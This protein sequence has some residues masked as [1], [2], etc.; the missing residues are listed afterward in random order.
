[1]TLENDALGK[2]HICR[3]FDGELATIYKL[4]LDMISLIR[5]QWELVIEAMEDANLES[6]LDIVAQTGDVHRYESRIDQAILILLAKE[7]PVASDLRMMLSISKIAAVMKYLGDEVDDMATLI[8]ALYEPRNGTP[9]A[10]LVTD[11]VKISQGIRAVLADLTADLNRLDSSQA[12]R[13]LQLDC[14]SDKH[15][16]DAFKRQLT[17]I[18]KDFRQIRPALTVLQIIKSLESSSDHCKNLAE[19]CIFMIDGQDLR[20]VG[21]L[22][23]AD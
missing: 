23:L 6:A 14:N 16:Q 22:P 20:H 10:R 5:E 4:V 3:H 18:N 21:R 1:M 13:V 9:N 7:S 17:F 15:I 11:I 8:L 12:R 2:P 19:Y